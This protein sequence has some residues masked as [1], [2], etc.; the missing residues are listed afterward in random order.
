[1]GTLQKNDP[2]IFGGK[3]SEKHRYVRGYITEDNRYLVI[4][5]STSTSGNKLFI[6]DLTEENSTLKT[7]VGHFDSDT[8]LIQNTIPSYI[9]LRILMHQIKNWS[10]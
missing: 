2:V 7:V 9:W 3:L 1:M 6:K 4:S 8:Y 5:A 10:P